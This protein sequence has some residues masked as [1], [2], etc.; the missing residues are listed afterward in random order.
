MWSKLIRR[1]FRSGGTCRT[2][3]SA[4]PVRF[5]PS[6]SVL[7]GRE[8]PAIFAVFAAGNLAVFGDAQ[9]NAITVSRNAAGT[10]LV[11][12]GNVT[13]FGGTPTVTNTRGITVFGQ[14]G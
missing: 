3:K 6:L 4:H 1:W 12:G 5:T 2:G 13:V 8:V 9:D 7:E 14:A 11:N 10:I